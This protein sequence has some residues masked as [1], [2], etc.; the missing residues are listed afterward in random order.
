[1]SL[2]VTNDENFEEI[3]EPSLTALGGLYSN[4]PIITEFT[5]LITSTRIGKSVLMMD[6]KVSRS[7]YISRWVD[8]ENIT[9]VR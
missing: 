6:V 3:E 5:R 2:I 8:R 1:M 9:Y 4:A 7:I